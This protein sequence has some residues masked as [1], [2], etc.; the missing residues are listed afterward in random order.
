VKQS[1]KA[2]LVLAMMLVAVA[3]TVK[4]DPPYTVVAGGLANPRGLTFG[5][6]GRLFVAQA[7][8][9]GNTGK[10][11]EIQRPTSVNPSVR[12]VITGLLSIPGENP[13]EFVGVDG[14]SALGNGNMAAII[15]ESELGGEPAP[16][17]HLLQFNIAGQSRDLA[18]VGSYNYAWSEAHQ[19]LAPNDFLPGDSNPYG[20]L[21][22]PGG[23]YVAD[24]GTNTLN[25]VKA[26]GDISILAYFPNNI[27][28]DATPTCIA[29]GPDGALYVGTLALVDSIVMGPRAKVYRVDPTQANPNDLDTIVTLAQPWATGLWPIT[30]CA[31]GP[32][33]SFY[34]SQFFTRF[35]P[36][37][38]SPFHDGDVVKID[39]TTGARTSLTSRTLDMPGG[40]AVGPDGA[41]YVSNH[42]AFVPSGEVVRLTS[43]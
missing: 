25:F 30:G 9:G 26:N 7:G 19:Y 33:G 18:N 41:V 42:S 39:F 13:G 6:G 31:V 21:A 20:V 28:A 35:Q 17:G 2:V 23:V 34:A 4:A 12:D 11:S 3:A 40:V 22:V 29:K 32:D 15:G 1:K 43:K 37:P 8:L 10:I 27:I 38:G 14:I 16:A 5:P 36:G 24:A